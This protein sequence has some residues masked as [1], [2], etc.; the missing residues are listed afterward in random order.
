MTEPTG[1]PLKEQWFPL[2]CPNC[3]QSAYDINFAAAARVGS[4]NP[5][6]LRRTDEKAMEPV[7]GL[8][9][10]CPYCKAPLGVPNIYPTVGGGYQISFQWLAET[11]ETS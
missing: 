5:D 9:F 1:P 8:T 6:H 10:A 2:S 11:A 7:L 4:I 3:H